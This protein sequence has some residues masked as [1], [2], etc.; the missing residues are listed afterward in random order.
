MARATAAVCPHCRSFRRRR[1][2]RKNINNITQTINCVLRGRTRNRDGKTNKKKFRER[3][4]CR[5]FFFF[6]F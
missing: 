3:G 5:V 4:I 6:F 2:R 1:R